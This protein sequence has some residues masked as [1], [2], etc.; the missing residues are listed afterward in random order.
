MA[1]SKK[2][3]RKNES[4]KITQSYPKIRSYGANATLSNINTTQMKQPL[5]E[6]VA[7]DE[8]ILTQQII[9]D[10]S[11]IN[12][13]DNMKN[14]NSNNQVPPSTEAHDK[15]T[16]KIKAP[17]SKLSI[18]AI[19]LSLGLS[20]FL[21]FQGHSYIVQ[22]QQLTAELHNEIASLKETLS[23]TLKQDLQNTIQ[24]KLEQQNQQLSTLQQQVNTQ[25][26]KQIQSQQQFVNQIKDALN[27]N[28]RNI[29]NLNERLAAM[30]TTDNSAWLISQANYLVHLA[31]RKI[32]NEQDY[33]S[34][35]LL[36]K[37][38]DGSLAE[39]QDPS[40]LPARQAISQDISALA[41]I[42]YTDFDGIVMSLM[43]LS[44]ALTTLP[45]IANYQDVD[46]AMMNYDEVAALEST[47]ENNNSENDNIISDDISINVKVNDQVTSFSFTELANNLLQSSQ[48]FFEKFVQIEKY[49]SYS[50]CISDAG[51]NE[52]QL[53]KCRV[54]KALISPE[55]ALYLREN[56]RLQLLIAAQ[57]VPRHQDLIYQQSLN[58]VA[59]WVRAYFDTESPD[60]KVFLSELTELQ[61][62]SISN[63]FVPDRLS[64]SAAL[65]KLMQT[66]VRSLLAN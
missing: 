56:I 60:V 38:A 2:K 36:L 64:S 44:D 14:N 41:K 23:V 45:L 47:T 20:G 34:A 8:S 49:D 24:S 7:H 40:L 31:G 11:I 4:T 39:A 25:L 13:K 35:R 42:S 6:A 48:S 28:E 26:D 57:S 54:H 5:I 62:Q 15:T 10:S 53:E 37:S 19:A 32:W 50:D 66:R 65:E 3:S 17:I 29:N 46:I 58:D 61:S 52:A 59:V 51:Q 12:K 16:T 18:I 55:Q 9:S 27:V 63:Q 21:Y 1:L 30:S 22:Q 43:R 33:V